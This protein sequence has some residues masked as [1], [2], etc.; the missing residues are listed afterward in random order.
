MVDLAQRQHHANY[1]E[2]RNKCNLGFEAELSNFWH[3]V[4]PTDPVGPIACPCQ[5]WPSSW[6]KATFFPPSVLGADTAV[7]EREGG[8]ISITKQWP[9][10]F[11]GWDSLALKFNGNKPHLHRR[12]AGL[13]GMVYIL[14]LFCFS[15][16]FFFIS[17]KRF[18]RKWM[19]KRDSTMSDCY[20]P[21]KQHITEAKTEPL[22]LLLE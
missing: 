7:M 15:W 3:M 5:I 21:N 13:M 17:N 22:S 9:M 20:D 2:S 18:K 19:L 11:L 8:F 10:P 6:G 14:L 16:I 12:D 1:L 4:L